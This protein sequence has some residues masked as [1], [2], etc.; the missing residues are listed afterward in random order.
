MFFLGG[1]EAT[2]LPG[3]GSRKFP[4]KER[5]LV[6][7][8]PAGN[9]NLVVFGPILGAL[10]TWRNSGPGQKT[11]KRNF[12]VLGGGGIRPHKRVLLLS[13]AILLRFPFYG[14]ADQTATDGNPQSTG[15]EGGFGR[16]RPS[17]LRVIPGSKQKSSTR[18]A[19][20]APHSTRGPERKEKSPK[21]IPDHLGCLER[22]A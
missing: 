21:M 9:S 3:M 18:R 16:G 6:G 8:P 7:A 13:P 5:F 19:P 1:G 11:R 4:G 2:T 12:P 20:G 10:G 15:F 14:L 17:A 22:C